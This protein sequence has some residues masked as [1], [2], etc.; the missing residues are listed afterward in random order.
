MCICYFS[1]F[2]RDIAEKMSSIILS[3]TA[4]HTQ[5]LFLCCICFGQEEEGSQDLQKTPQKLQET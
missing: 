2:I 1:Q 3:S 5:Q 4:D